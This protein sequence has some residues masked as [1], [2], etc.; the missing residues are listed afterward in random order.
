MR[1]SS[2]GT[3]PTT[4]TIQ[5][6][7]HSSVG[8]PCCS[9]RGFPEIGARRSVV[10]SCCRSV[11]SRS[12][13]TSAVQ[14]GQQVSLVIAIFTVAQN[15]SSTVSRYT[16]LDGRLQR[17]SRCCN[18]WPQLVRLGLRHGANGVPFSRC[19]PRRAAFLHISV[20]LESTPRAPIYWTHTCLYRHVIPIRGTS[21]SNRASDKHAWLTCP[22]LHRWIPRIARSGDR[23]CVDFRHLPHAQA[24]LCY[25]EST[26]K[27]YLQAVF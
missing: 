21:G 19:S 26:S 7:S 24:S 1:I 17:A 13:F 18:S 16:R 14:F 25:C 9:H 2:T 4:K 15:S 23:W 27:A 22:P 6:M 5:G 10:S 3:V 11:S 8:Y 20:D 12:Q